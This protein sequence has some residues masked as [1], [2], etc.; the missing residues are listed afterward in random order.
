V[1]P[2]EVISECHESFRSAGRLAGAP[3]LALGS[4]ATAPY[5][6]GEVNADGSILGVIV[7]GGGP[8]ACLPTSPI[9]APEPPTPIGRPG[10]RGLEL[11]LGRCGPVAPSELDTG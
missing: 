8:V 5:G 6:S 3:T 9:V 1:V 4:G 11:E 7:F 10:F 2:T